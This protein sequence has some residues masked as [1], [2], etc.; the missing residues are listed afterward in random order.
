MSV[1]QGND[2]WDAAYSTR[3]SPYGSYMGGRR[4]NDAP[5]GDEVHTHD[6]SDDH[7]YLKHDNPSWGIRNIR[8]TKNENAKQLPQDD[9][10]QWDNEESNSRNRHD[11]A[12]QRFYDRDRDLRGHHKA[13]QKEVL[14]GI[15]DR[16]LDSNLGP[17]FHKYI[18][19]G[20]DSTDRHNPDR[21]LGSHTGRRQDENFHGVQPSSMGEWQDENFPDGPGSDDSYS[22]GDRRRTTVGCVLSSVNQGECS[23]G[24]SMCQMRSIHELESPPPYA[25]DGTG[26]ARDFQIQAPMMKF[27]HSESAAKLGIQMTCQA[28]DFFSWDGNHQQNCDAY[29]HALNFYRG[30]QIGRNVS[31]QFERYK[32]KEEWVYNDAE[33]S[34]KLETLAPGNQTFCTMDKRCDEWSQETLSEEECLSKP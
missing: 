1:A 15:A 25:S 33:D 19:G 16:F 28:T 9:Q 4:H 7:R 17:R 6:D 20:T 14:K 29:A 30:A 23:R 26:H 32:K 2:W 27:A 12:L 13:T 3:V 10:K 5:E 11:D 8:G 31:A 34:Y 18:S 21:F 22:P 24:N